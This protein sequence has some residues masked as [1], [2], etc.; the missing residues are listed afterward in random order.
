MRGCQRLLSVFGALAVLVATAVPAGA[1]S[2]PVGQAKAQVAQ[3]RKAAN[4]AAARYAKAES[5]YEQLGDAVAELD[6]RIAAT[7]TEAS[8]YRDAAQRRAVL[9]YRNGRELTAPSG[10]GD[11]LDDASR[12]VLLDLV[13]ASDTESASR[14]RALE[15]DL[16]SQQEA[17][18]AR[19]VEQQRALAQLKS[20]QRSLKAKLDASQK[21]QKALEDRLRRESSARAAVARSSRGREAAGQIIVNPGGRPWTCPVPGAAFTNDW[22]QPRSGGRHHQG[23]DMF[24]PRGA[25]NVAVV[26]GSMSSGSG[27]LGGTSALLAGDDG[28]TYYYAHLQTI[29]GGPRHVSQGEL[30]GRTGNTGNARGGPT[31][32]HFEIRPGGRKINP[33]PTLRAYC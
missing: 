31:H 10:V 3:A 8:K 18:K 15:A 29:V 5:R 7:E 12:H 20:E 16:Q 33:Y 23:T 6:R 26:A 25:P 9:A 21:A 27:G 1:K 14:L 28:V 22:G 24:A 4:D 32:T 30:I 11:A 2:D 19:R 13:N 17:M